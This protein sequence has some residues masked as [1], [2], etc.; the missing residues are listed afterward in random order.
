MSARRSIENFGRALA[1]FEEFA[2]RDL[3]D[4]AVQTAVVKAFELTFETAWKAVRG[5]VLEAGEEVALPRPSLAK[6]VEI[7]LISPED[8]EL[9][10]GMARDR[11]LAAHV[12]LPDVAEEIL[13]RLVGTY[14]PVARR[15]RDRLPA[16]DEE[17]T[18]V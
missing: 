14:L 5:V 8:G 2:A 13:P 18:V 17:D 10:N 6:G 7:G 4:V 1:R 11:N 3:T 9:W 15:L 12:Y 16:P